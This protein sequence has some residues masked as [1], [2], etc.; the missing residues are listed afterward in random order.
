MNDL[1][2]IKLGGSAITKKQEDKEEVST[3]NLKRLCSEISRAR[4]KTGFDL[5]IVHGAGPFGHV[6][7]KKHLLAEGFK[8][9]SQI[10][11]ITV[12]RSS[13]E[14]L[15]FS[16]V[17]ALIES[18]INAVSCQPS[19]MG[20]L[21][22]GKIDY[23]P[24]KAIEGF[25]SLGMVPVLYGDVVIDKNRGFGILSGDQI[26]QYVAEK[27]KAQRV[28]IATDVEGV[29]EKDPRDDP[30]AKI[31]PILDRIRIERL[32]A[33]DSKATDVTGGMRGK[34]SELA[35][36]AE[37][38]IDSAIISA[39]LPGRLQKALEGKEVPGTTIVKAQRGT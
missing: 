30:K 26:V 14:Q 4:R 38:G 9:P 32:S 2:I 33:G 39:L 18:G 37:A 3:E 34:L 29:F 27:L 19:A 8:D 1:V 20:I 16:V 5:I 31:I 21:K 23:F 25:I 11:G 35:V 15:N 6:P 7:A 12:T 13:M 22:T 24:T 17:T 28:I 10:E 36:L